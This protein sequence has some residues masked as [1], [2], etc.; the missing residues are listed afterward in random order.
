[1]IALRESFGPAMH[2]KTTGNN[3]RKT[4]A[5]RN[6]AAFIRIVFT[7]KRGPYVSECL[8]ILKLVNC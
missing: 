5:H 2:R 1:M 8:K 7:R 6:T 3:T 4:A